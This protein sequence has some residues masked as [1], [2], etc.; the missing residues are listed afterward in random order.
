MPKNSKGMIMP[1]FAEI[2]AGVFLNTGDIHATVMLREIAKRLR[3]A[4][5]GIA[6]II[7]DVINEAG[8][9][10]KPIAKQMQEEMDK[11][12]LTVDRGAPH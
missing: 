9:A 8:D 1:T 3:L 2:C 5:P 12:I 4:E 10:V 7:D 11:R 6:Q